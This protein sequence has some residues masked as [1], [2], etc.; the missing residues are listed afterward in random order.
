MFKRK[1]KSSVIFLALLLTLSAGIAYAQWSP[2]TSAPPVNPGDPNIDNPLYAGTKPDAQSRVGALTI[3]Q[4]VPNPGTQN[5]Y[6]AGPAVTDTTLSAGGDGSGCSLSY[7]LAGTA[8]VSAISCD[9]SAVYGSGQDPSKAGVYGVTAVNSGYGVWGN[10]GSH[11]ATGVYGKAGQGGYGVIGYSQAGSAGIFQGSTNITGNLSV[12]DTTTLSGNVAITNNLTT[13]A[14]QFNGIDF[15]PRN[16]KA[17]S[18]QNAISAVPVTD[19]SVRV[20]VL[21]SADGNGSGCTNCVTTGS[22]AGK[23]ANGVSVSWRRGP[24]TYPIGSEGVGPLNEMTEVESYLAEYSLD[25][26]TYFPYDRTSSDVNYEECLPGASLAS[27]KFTITN[28]LGYGAFFR[29]IAFYRQFSSVQVCGTVAPVPALEVITSPGGIDLI[30]PATF[31]AAPTQ[32]LRYKDATSVGKCATPGCYTCTVYYGT[33]SGAPNIIGSTNSGSLANCDITFVPT[34]SKYNAGVDNGIYIHAC[35]GSVC[36]NSLMITG[37]FTPTVTATADPTSTANAS[38]STIPPGTP[39]TVMFADLTASATGWSWSFGDGTCTG[40]A[41]NGLGCNVLNGATDC[42]SGVCT[43]SPICN[44]DN[45]AACGGPGHTAQNPAHTYV[46]NSTFTVTDTATVNGATGSGT[47]A[48]RV[49]CPSNY[50]CCNN[51]SYGSAYNPQ[52]GVCLAPNPYCR[53]ACTGGGGGCGHKFEP[54]CP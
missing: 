4:A 44:T 18:I 36:A 12:D 11:T 29:V 24:K 32:S 1:M 2:P 33:P 38:P 17:Q 13:E 19:P 5:L 20:L 31:S 8:A 54:P 15:D 53:T 46:S 42:P 25:G 28:S 22:P 6:V 51:Q 49:G 3:G 10:A 35:N 26:Y 16:V 41:N 48:V 30:N 43:A 37:K 50:Y 40:G 27:G 39:Q 9:Y 7:P 45:S 14:L 21:T 23:I 52:T 34:S 47:T